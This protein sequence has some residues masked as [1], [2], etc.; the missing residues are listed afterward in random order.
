MC[1]QPHYADQKIAGTFGKQYNPHMGG[2]DLIQPSPGTQEPDHSR[3]FILVAIAVVVGLVLVAALLLREPVK[4]APKISP[5]AAKLQ[6][7]DIKMSQ[8]QNFVGASVTYVDGTVA[9]SGD[10]VV[11]RAVVRVTFRD[12]YGQVAQIEDMPIKLLQT[13]GPYPDTVDLAAAPLAAGQSKPFRMIF[14]HVS[15]QWNQAAP[16]L[17]IIEVTLK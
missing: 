4:S 16:E 5:Y 9:N 12:L 15:E 13:S 10:R 8:A 1:R 17:K 11:S 6:I 2:L 14:E 3:R 7:S